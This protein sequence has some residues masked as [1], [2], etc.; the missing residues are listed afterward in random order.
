M[1]T[2][3]KRSTILIVED[4]KNVAAVLEA[5]LQSFGY[6]V[7]A[8][9]ETGAQAIHQNRSHEPD[10]ILMDILLRGDMNG[11]E[12]AEQIVSGYDVPIIYL[13]CLNTDEVMDRAAKTNPYGYIIKPYN[14]SELRLTIEIALVKHAAAKEREK[15]IEALKKS[16]EEIKRLSG[17]LPI[18]AKCKR[19]RDEQDNWHE[20]E[21]Y[22]SKHSEADFSHGLC[23]DCAR[24]LY[25]ELEIPLTCK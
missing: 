3:K 13:S 25:P 16:L 24:V 23:P 19:I 11:I 1:V 7:C 8:V 14:N 21:T 17:L 10:L 12:T 9:A 22:V 20:I 2:T 6:N 5:R 4:D 15:L 18:C